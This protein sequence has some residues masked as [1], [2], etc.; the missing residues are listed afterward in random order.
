MTHLRG[1]FAAVLILG[2]S[3]VGP[4]PSDAAPEGQMTW[5]VHISRAPTWFDPAET[6]GIGTPFMVLCG[7]YPDIGPSV[8]RTTVNVAAPARSPRR[9]SR[10]LL[11]IERSRPYERKGF[12]LATCENRAKSPSRVRISCTPCSSANATRCAS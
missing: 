1:L 4:S 9:G 6:S 10:G 5:G 7:S 8:T 2:I 11:R 12:R 3:A